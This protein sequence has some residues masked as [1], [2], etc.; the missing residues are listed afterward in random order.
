MERWAGLR[1]LGTD[2]SSLLGRDRLR[3]IFGPWIMS[4]SPMILGCLQGPADARGHETMDCNYWIVYIPLVL[5]GFT[6]RG[7]EDHHPAY[8]GRAGRACLLRWIASCVHVH[9]MILTE[10]MVSAPRT[11]AYS[12]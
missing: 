4:P 6:G 12:T 2:P 5:S 11:L 1:E 9:D 7:Q 3:L 10:S 8:L